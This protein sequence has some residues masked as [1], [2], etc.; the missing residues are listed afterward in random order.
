MDA[1]GKNQLQEIAKT[2]NQVSYI[3]DDDDVADFINRFQQIDK[4]EYLEVIAG[5]R[6]WMSFLAANRIQNDRYESRTRR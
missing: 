2:N 4:K 1:R 5:M 6:I 3:I